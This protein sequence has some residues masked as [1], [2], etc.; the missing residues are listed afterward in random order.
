MLRSTLASHSHLGPPWEF[1][2]WR[3][4]SFPRPLASATI[5]ADSAAA[6]MARVADNEEH[7]AEINNN[8]M[9]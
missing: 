2:N 3:H 4:N 8:I 9:K 7:Q 6:A 1:Y 5:I